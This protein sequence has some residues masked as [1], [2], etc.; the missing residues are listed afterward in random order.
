LEGLGV[1]GDNIKMDFKDIG[2]DGVDWIHLAQDRD[3][4]RE[5]VNTI[6]NLRDPQ[7][8]EYSVSTKSLRGFEKLWRAKKLI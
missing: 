2:W 6:M 5:L 8:T 7:K 3:R 4:W 1:I